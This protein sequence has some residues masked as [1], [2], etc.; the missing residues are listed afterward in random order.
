MQRALRPFGEPAR[1]GSR[2]AVQ[3]TPGRGEGKLTTCAERCL[4]AGGSRVQSTTLCCSPSAAPAPAPAL[5][6]T[7]YAGQEMVWHTLYSSPRPSSL[8]GR[9]RAAQLAAAAQL[10]WLLAWHSLGRAL[11]DELPRIRTGRP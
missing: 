5:E 11:A 4:A 1:G 3:L 8:H 6:L 7:G 2:W 9:C 10:L